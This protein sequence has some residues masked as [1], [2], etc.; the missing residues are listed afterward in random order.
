MSKNKSKAKGTKRN[1]SVILGFML[2]IAITVLI[3]STL[4]HDTIKLSEY[5]CG[6]GKKPV[7]IVPLTFSQNENKGGSCKFRVIP[8]PEV[9]SLMELRNELSTGNFLPPTANME[10]KNE[11]TKKVMQALPPDDELRKYYAVRLWVNVDKTQPSKRYA[12]IIMKESEG[13]NRALCWAQGEYFSTIMNKVSFEELTGLFDG[14]ALFAIMSE[15]DRTNFVELTGIK[16]TPPK[17]WDPMN[18][19]VPDCAVLHWIDQMGKDGHFVHPIPNVLV[20]SG[21]N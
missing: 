16:S 10:V 14:V 12:F 6:P 17:T 9:M 4:N 5:D 2:L 11:L 21:C 3:I 8:P 20:Q 18:N 7:L 13:T 15:K 1:W 19:P